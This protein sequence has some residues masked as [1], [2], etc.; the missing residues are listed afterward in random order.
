MSNIQIIIARL[1]KLENE[2]ALLKSQI[3][4]LKKQPNIKP[5]VINNIIKN[6]SI[7][8]KEIIEMICGKI[9]LDYINRLYGK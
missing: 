3:R 9:T 8:K 4:E 1:D 2:N 5:Q 7:S 6:D